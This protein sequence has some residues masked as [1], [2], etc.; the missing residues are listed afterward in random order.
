MFKCFLHFNINTTTIEKKSCSPNISIGK[1]ITIYVICK[2]VLRIK[3][4]GRVIEKT[5]YTLV[6]RVS[7]FAFRTLLSTVASVYFWFKVARRLSKEEFSTFSCAT[8]ND[9]APYSYQHCSSI[10]IIF[11]MQINE[12]ILRYHTWSS[13]SFK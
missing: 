4:I 13:I 3:C 11:S 9:V 5:S 2:K 1:F 10:P 8:C 7:M 12:A 6:L